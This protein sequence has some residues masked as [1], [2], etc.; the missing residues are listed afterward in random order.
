VLFV[1]SSPTDEGRVLLDPNVLSSDGTMAVSAISVSP[2]RA[3][4]AYAL[5]EGGSDWLTWRLREVESGEDLPDVVL[6]SKF[7]GASWSA[8]GAGFY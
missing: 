3:L 8:D 5:S 1:M 7:S 2:D 6:W 4:L